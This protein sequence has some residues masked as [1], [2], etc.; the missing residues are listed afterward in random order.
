MPELSSV[1]QGKSY[2]IW[3]QRWSSQGECILD[4]RGQ[5]TQNQVTNLGVKQ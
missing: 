2:C 4:S 1:K 3:K 5:T